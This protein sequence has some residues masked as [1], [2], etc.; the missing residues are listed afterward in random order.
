[1]WEVTRLVRP[2]IC[3]CVCVCVCA[4][5]RV[6]VC[7]CV[8]ADARYHISVLLSDGEEAV[9]AFGAMAVFGPGIGAPRD[10]SCV[11]FVCMLY[12]C[13]VY[14]MLCCVVLCCVF[15]CCVHYVHI[16]SCVS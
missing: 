13:V 11:C 9:A 2:F 12:V 3:V 1:M 5:A 6:C 7:V 10:A 8:C 15:V 16:A 14:V 4:R